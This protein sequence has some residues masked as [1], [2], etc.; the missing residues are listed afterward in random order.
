MERLDIRARVVV[1][2][3]ASVASWDPWPQ[4]P[5]VE[6]HLLVKRALMQGIVVFDY[7]PRY[8]EA[9]EVLADWVRNGLIRYREDILD[10]IEQAP[11]S[12]AGLY[13]GENLGKRLIRVSSE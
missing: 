1:C 10:G 8:P 7:R 9:L 6:R 12:I 5:R 13:R 3:T 11:G 2:G 4:G